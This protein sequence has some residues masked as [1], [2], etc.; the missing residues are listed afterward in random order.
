MKLRWMVADIFL[1]KGLARLLFMGKIGIQSSWDGCGES[2]G[3][4][5]V[6]LLPEFRNTSPKISSH[7]FERRQWLTLVLQRSS[8]FS[9][10]FLQEMFLLQVPSALPSFLLL[11]LAIF[12]Y[13]LCFMS[14]SVSLWVDAWAQS[15]VARRSPSS[16]CLVLGR[17]FWEA[18]GAWG[19]STQ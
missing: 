17:G 11:F 6:N 1:C 19:R 4:L 3:W 5:Q 16:L 9:S 13:N 12:P 2:G 10:P 14:H 18:G 8:I 15:V 7:T